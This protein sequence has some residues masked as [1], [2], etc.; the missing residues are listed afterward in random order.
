[1]KAEIP[2]AILLARRKKAA[3][4]AFCLPQILGNWNFTA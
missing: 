2:K 4:G 1:M 3:E